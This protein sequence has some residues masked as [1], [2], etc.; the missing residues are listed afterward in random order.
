M[1]R[2]LVQTP[3]FYLTSIPG[4]GV[5]LAA[6]TMAATEAMEALQRRFGTALVVQVVTTLRVLGRPSFT[7]G[8]ADLQRFTNALSGAADLSGRF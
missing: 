4:V 8:V 5:V 7:L 6:H 2:G 3:G 1:A